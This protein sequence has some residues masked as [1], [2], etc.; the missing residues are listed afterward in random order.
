[1]NEL[2]DHYN[3]SFDHEKAKRDG[4]IIPS[5]GLNPDYDNA[6]NDIKRIEKDFAD[7]LKDQISTF[8]TVSIRINKIP[9][10]KYF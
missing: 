7:Y 1:M 6:I 2:L 8:G 9:T 5:P 3:N 10:F 4:K